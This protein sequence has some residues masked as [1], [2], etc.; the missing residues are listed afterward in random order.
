MTVQTTFAG[1]VNPWA[2][3]FKEVKEPIGRGAKLTI[4]VD[5][6]VVKDEN[7]AR[8]K[9]TEVLK[10]GDIFGKI[11]AGYSMQ[12]ASEDVQ[13]ILDSFQRYRKTNGLKL[14]VD[15]SRG[16]RLI[17]FSERAY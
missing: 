14:R 11:K 10:Y 7:D 2:I 4:N 16:Q 13:K 9:I 15:V 1:G 17:R 6:L 8:I 5:E 3:Y 12:C